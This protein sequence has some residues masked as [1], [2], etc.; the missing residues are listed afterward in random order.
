MGL[1]GS[2]L[3]QSSHLVQHC[4]LL[5]VWQGTWT[6]QLVLSLTMK[7]KLYLSHSAC[8]AIP[9]QLKIKHRVGEISLACRAELK[10]DTYITM[11]DCLQMR[12][13]EGSGLASAHLLV[14]VESDSWLYAHTDYAHYVKD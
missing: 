8:K 13:P 5:C 9:K 12:N 6:E 14:A 10:L 2:I 1:P 4:I 7:S 11:A 3:A